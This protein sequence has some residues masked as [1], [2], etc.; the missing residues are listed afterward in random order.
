MYWWD[1]WIAPSCTTSQLTC[2][3]SCWGWVYT[4]KAWENCSWWDEWQACNTQSCSWG[5]SSGGWWGWWGWSTWPS[6]WNYTVKST[7]KSDFSTYDN[8]D[9]KDL[10]DWEVPVVILLKHT[11]GKYSAQFLKWTKVLDKDGKPYK[12]KI[13]APKRLSNNDM[14]EHKWKKVALRALEFWPEWEDITFSKWVKL[15][16]SYAGL[17]SKIDPKNIRI[18]SYNEKTKEYKLEDWDRVIDEKNKTI[19]IIVSHFTKFI[20]TDWELSW[21]DNSNSSNFSDNNNTPFTDISS[22]WSKSYIENL[23]KKW[24]LANK[25][26]YNPDTQLNRIEL[27]KM[28]TEAF[29]YWKNSDLSNI[30]FNDIDLNSWYPEYL[31]SA[32]EKWIVNWPTWNTSFRPWDSVNRAEAMKM[33]LEASWLN[34][35]VKSW[36][37][38][39]VSNQW[40]RNYVNFAANKWI[41]SWYWDWIFKP[42]NNVT[43]W[44]V[45]KMLMKTVEL[46]E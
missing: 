7:L 15:V 28:V 43:R 13:D 12:W 21:A 19:T 44:E 9:L 45:A 33:I 22:H 31:S 30:W 6:V 5:S 37:F 4:I 10:E 16:F 23:Y 24:V 34:V 41:V 25:T 36:I 11:T 29:W 35:E 39:D 32:V 8:L 38:S 26:K 46:V 40:F 18:Y 42:W 1:W 27:V 3:L 20:M 2:S 17:S 14:P